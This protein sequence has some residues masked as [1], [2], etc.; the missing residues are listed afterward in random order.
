MMRIWQTMD[1]NWWA[2]VI[3]LFSQ[4]II[5]PDSKDSLFRHVT[6]PGGTEPLKPE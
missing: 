5:F 3:A 2:F 6:L 1:L 4:Y